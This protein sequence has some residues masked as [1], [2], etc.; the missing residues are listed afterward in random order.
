MLDKNALLRMRFSEELATGLKRK[1]WSQKKLA[2]ILEV[3]PS[4]VNHWCT[5]GS[6][7]SLEYIV[8][9]CDLL[10]ISIAWL[11][12]QESTPQPQDIYVRELDGFRWLVHYHEHLDTEHIQFL[13]QGINIIEKV[14]IDKQSPEQ[15]RPNLQ[16][17][18][19]DVRNAVKAALRARAFQCLHIPRETS[20][21]RKLAH[22]LGI[23][24]GSIIIADVPHTISEDVIRTEFVA[25]LA[26]T[27]VLP[28]VRKK[29][30]IGIG[31]GYTIL[32]MCEISVPTDTLFSLSQ[33]VPLTAPI[34]KSQHQISANIAVQTLVNRHANSQ[35]LY[36]PYV[37]GTPS[38]YA[39][40]A[41]NEIMLTLPE[42]KLA[43]VGING[44]RKGTLLNQAG[45]VDS[46]LF[47]ADYTPLPRGNLRELL[48]NRIDDFSFEM[49]GIFFDKA[50]N[51]FEGIPHPTPFRY[52]HHLQVQH[53]QDIVKRG[54]LWIIAAN[55][56]KAEPIYQALKHKLANAL[57]IDS[58]IAS[59][60]LKQPALKL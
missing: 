19:D 36:Y 30:S 43:F 20:M 23:V 15:V 45:N 53:I 49:L 10:S 58:E 39:R 42:I 24:N 14:I 29:P 55:A 12:D 17:D 47:F 34:D 21:E 59:Y 52:S 11:L 5:A 41:Y 13:K 38:D 51:P 57:V 35:D 26:A 31:A 40:A 44:L 25:Y 7:P 4:T 37:E 54:T 8:N 27:E 6:L 32:R 18:R 56:Y 1:E 60:L 22:H 48:G 46:Q 9:I 16:W 3:H 2:T 28:F 50:G 33:W